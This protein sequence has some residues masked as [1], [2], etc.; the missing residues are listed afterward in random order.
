VDLQTLGKMLV[1]MALALAIVGAMFWVAGRVGMSGMPGNLKFEGD[2]WTCFVPIAASIVIS[3]LLTI[4][5]NV[6]IRWFR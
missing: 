6:V 1:I 3:I 4:V 2:G 5:L